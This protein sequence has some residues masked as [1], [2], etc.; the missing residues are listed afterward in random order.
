[1]IDPTTKAH[2]RTLE[3]AHGIPQ[4]SP[5]RKRSAFADACAQ[6]GSR[7]SCIVAGSKAV[8]IARGLLGFDHRAHRM[9]GVRHMSQTRE[10]DT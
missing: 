10:S 8:G 5:S 7:R 2:L 9:L 6:D 3:N 1:M 4:Y